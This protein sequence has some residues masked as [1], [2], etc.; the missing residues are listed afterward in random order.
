MHISRV[1]LVLLGI[2]CVWAVKKH[3][4]VHNKPPE[5][6]ILL[7]AQ[8]GPWTQ[9]ATTTATHWSG[10]TADSTGQFLVACSAGNGTYASSDFGWTWTASHNL[11][12]RTLFDI[13]SNA[14]GQTVIVSSISIGADVGGVYVSTNYGYN[15][16]QTALST[17][18][19]WYGVSCDDSGTNMAQC[20]TRPIQMVRSTT[21][22]MA[23][24]HGR[25]AMRKIR[26]GAPY[27]A[28]Q[29][30]ST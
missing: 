9:I 22:G 10:V 23:E 4:R 24:P 16:T 19:V 11:L 20:T 13:A 7:K 27:R 1:V 15:W 25:R 18:E 26:N 28:T 8:S 21:A 29:P 12:N 30:A 14:S 17:S 5:S 3:D 2:F 6:S